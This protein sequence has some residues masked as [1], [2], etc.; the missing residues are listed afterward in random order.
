MGWGHLKIIWTMK[1]K[2]LNFTWK[3]PDIKQRQVD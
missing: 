3:L 1:P 2:M